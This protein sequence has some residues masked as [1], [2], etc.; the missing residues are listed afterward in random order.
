[1]NGI[2]TIMERIRKR[3]TRTHE[4]TKTNTQIPAEESNDINDSGEDVNQ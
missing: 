3:N 1:M 4:H 2:R